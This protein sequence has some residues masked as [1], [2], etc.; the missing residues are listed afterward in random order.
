MSKIGAIVLEAQTIAQDCWNES[1]S[2]LVKV[3][4]ERNANEPKWKQDYI[5]ENA[6][7]YWEEI[8]S[9]FQTYF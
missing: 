3:V 8:Q 1:K 9:D 5:L 6:E 7:E 2:E 4:Q